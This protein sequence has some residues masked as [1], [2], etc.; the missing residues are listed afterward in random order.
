M[1]SHKKNSLKVRTESLPKGAKENF[2]IGSSFPMSKVD[3]QN[4]ENPSGFFTTKKNIIS[5]QLFF[6]AKASIK[7]KNKFEPTGSR[8]LDSDFKLKT[9][10][11]NSLNYNQKDFT[12]L[13]TELISFQLSK[14]T[15]QKLG[16]FLKLA[17]FSMGKFK[18][19]LP[20]KEFDL[21]QPSKQLSTQSSILSDEDTLFLFSSLA[22]SGL[23][24]FKKNKFAYPANWSASFD[25]F[26][27]WF[28]KRF[29][30]K[31][32]GLILIE[33]IFLKGMVQDKSLVSKKRVLQK[34]NRI[35]LFCP[36]G[37][38]LQSPLLEGKGQENLASVKYF[39]KKKIKIFMTFARKAKIFLLSQP[40][41]GLPQQC[42]KTIANIA[43]ILIAN[44]QI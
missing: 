31:T 7:K 10:A 28:P 27:N 20:E 32:G 21:M 8:K 16:Y 12:L 19:S 25:I 26:L 44:F 13:K 14:I 4:K 36:T 33:P 22:K 29:S 42:R 9:S 6:L 38:S 15:Y 43:Q 24:K 30:T 2:R 11:V 37:E 35:S 39:K 40:L 18:F 17:P 1:Y 34:N 3:L 23:S 41:Y 5:S